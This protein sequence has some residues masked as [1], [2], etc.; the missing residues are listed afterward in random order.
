MHIV[1]AGEPQNE[2]DFDPAVTEETDL[3]PGFAQGLTQDHRVLPVF[4]W[5]VR[6]RGFIHKNADCTAGG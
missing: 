2:F 6:G 4:G 5:D 1:G 3:P